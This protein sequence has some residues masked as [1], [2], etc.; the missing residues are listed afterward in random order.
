MYKGSRAALAAMC[1]LGAGCEQQPVEPT[2]P[3]STYD[4][5]LASPH[6]RGARAAGTEGAPVPLEL[7]PP[8]GPPAG[9][10][11][12]LEPEPEP[13]PELDAGSPLSDP[14]PFNVPL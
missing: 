3:P 13:E 2:L 1:L 7:Q 6:A 11:G 9:A 14:K 4:L 12:L 8:A 10:G 5:P